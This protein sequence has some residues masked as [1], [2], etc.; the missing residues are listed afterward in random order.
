MFNSNSA[1]N[2]W[3]FVHNIM[4]ESDNIHFFYLQIV[5]QTSFF[6][7]ELLESVSKLGQHYSKINFCDIRATVFLQSYMITLGGHSPER[8]L[9]SGRLRQSFWNSD[10][11]G[12]QRIIFKVVAYGR[13]SLTRSGHYERVDCTWILSVNNF[14]KSH[15]W[16]HSQ[17][18]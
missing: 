4:H 12:N 13:W 1:W 11:L 6:V 18:W 2:W 15:N 16:P 9:G 14:R 8:N 3:N 5:L 17:H 10:W 7:S